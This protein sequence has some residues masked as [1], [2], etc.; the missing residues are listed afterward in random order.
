MNILLS[1]F[2]AKHPVKARRLKR[3]TGC[4][5]ENCSNAFP[6]AALELYF[7]GQQPDIDNKNVDL[8]EHLL[9]LCPGCG[10][11]FRSGNVD[12]SLQKEL[13][14]HRMPKIRD[15]IR[16][17]LEYRPRDYTPPGDFDLEAVFQEMIDSGAIDLCLNG[18]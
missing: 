9:I 7:I 2:L 18:G 17:I 5:C 6:M 13:V 12:V 8:Q 14:C 3:A 1:K 10:R 16:E 15:Q 11:S 4:R